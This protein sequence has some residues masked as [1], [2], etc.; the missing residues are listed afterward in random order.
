MSSTYDLLED[1]D[2][3]FLCL[4]QMNAL[5]FKIHLSSSEV[6]LCYEDYTFICTSVAFVK[7]INN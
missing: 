2:V 3:L 4:E 5:F 7:L 1:C 6:V